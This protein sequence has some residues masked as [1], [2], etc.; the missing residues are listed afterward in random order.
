MKE[1]HARSYNQVKLAI[2]KEKRRDYHK[3]FLSFFVFCFMLCKKRRIK[4]STAEQLVF[5]K[6]ILRFAVERSRTS[7]KSN[8]VEHANRRHFCPVSKSEGMF[9]F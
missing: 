9:C 2:A 5:L 3:F 1:I 6:F 8:L 7:I 4:E